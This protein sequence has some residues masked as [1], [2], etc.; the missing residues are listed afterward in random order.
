MHNKIKEYFNVRKSD[1]Q[2]YYLENL[3]DWSLNKLKTK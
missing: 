2:K 1:S 3:L